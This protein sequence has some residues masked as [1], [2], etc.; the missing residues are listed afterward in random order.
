MVIKMTCNWQPVGFV[1]SC[2]YTEA[3]M[4]VGTFV[5]LSVPDYYKTNETRLY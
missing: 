2:N 4:F 3:V 5:C 1:D